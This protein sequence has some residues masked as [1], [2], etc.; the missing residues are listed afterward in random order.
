MNVYAVMSLVA[1]GVN[2]SV[3]IYV[4]TRSPRTALNQLFFA[5]MISLAVWSAGEFVMRVSL[6]SHQATWG[7]RV[8]AVGWCLVGGFFVLF[9]LAFTENMKALRDRRVQIA[10][11]LPGVA[12]LVLVWSS[13]LIFRGFTKSY[14][15][16]EEIAGTL[17]IPSKLFV[18]VLFVIGGV[19][20]LRF[21]R[22]AQSRYKRVG[23]AYV[24]I[25]LAIPLAA[26]IITDMILPAF[27]Y[28]TV[29]LPMFASTACA[30]IIG[31]AVVSLGLMTTIAGR[32]GGTIITRMNDAVFVTNAD[33]YVETV[34]GAAS[35]LT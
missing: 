26:G 3:G 5:V 12:F 31:Y 15:G 20:L 35:R 29:E 7:G 23:A 17:R 11:L 18:V 14:W 24:L 33:G 32:L 27:G 22:T 8:A 25:A 30:P 4:L 16:Y 6:S 1:L 34:N 13:N 21:W 19:M 10:C 9:A 2:L 28:R